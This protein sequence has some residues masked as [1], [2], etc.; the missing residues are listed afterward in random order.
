MHHDEVLMKSWFHL[1]DAILE[2]GFPFSRA[3]GM[4]AFE[5][6]ETDQRFNRLFNEGI[7]SYTTLVVKKILDVYRGFDGLNVLVDVGGGTGV[8]LSIIASKYPHIKGINYDLPHVLA[9]SPSYSGIK[10]CSLNHK[11][12]SIS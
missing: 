2:G 6:L 7:S 1:N 8:T 10:V 3:H 4:T 5:Y 9:N 12:V 11:R